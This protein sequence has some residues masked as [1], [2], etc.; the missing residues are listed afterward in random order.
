MLVKDPSKR[1]EWEELFE[2]NITTEGKIVEG[3]SKKDHMKSD[4][5]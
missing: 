4:N 3:S 1:I 2:I 5:E